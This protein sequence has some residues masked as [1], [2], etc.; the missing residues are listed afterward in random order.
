MRAPIESIIVSRNN[1]KPPSNGVCPRIV[2]L[3]RGMLTI[4]IISA[5]PTKRLVI[6]AAEKILFLNIEIL[7]NGSGIRIDRKMK[8]AERSM[9][10]NK[11]PRR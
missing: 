2:S 9:A 3:M 8:K 10:R 7:I 5:P 4:A 1:L 6:F 11:K